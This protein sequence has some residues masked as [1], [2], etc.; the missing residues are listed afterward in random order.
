MDLYED[1][2]MSVGMVAITVAAYA[3]I[4][5]SEWIR[6]LLESML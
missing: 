2:A 6:P 3:L 4:M 1:I 5:K